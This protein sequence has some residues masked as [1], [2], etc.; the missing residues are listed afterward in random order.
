MGGAPA[1]NAEELEEV[2]LECVKVVKDMVEREILDM[3][4]VAKGNGDSNSQ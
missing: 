2:E 1:D 4:A 3:M